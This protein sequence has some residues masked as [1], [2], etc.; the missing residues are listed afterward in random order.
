MPG[1][2]ALLG[3]FVT[4]P[5]PGLIGEYVIWDSLSQSDTFS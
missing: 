2:R 3:V 4:V 1:R 5:A